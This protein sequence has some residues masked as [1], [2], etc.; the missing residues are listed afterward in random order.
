MKLLN[1]L[2]NWLEK[3]SGGS[4]A[5]NPLKEEP[6][7][8]FIYNDACSGSTDAPAADRVVFVDTNRG[9]H[10]VIVNHRGKICHFPGIEER[11]K[12][13]S[14]IDNG[15]L[16]PYARYHV[17]FDKRDDGYMMT[18]IVQPDGRYWADSDGFGAESDEEVCLYAMMDNNGRFTSPF[19]LY[20]IGVKNYFHGT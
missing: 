19:R 5:A 9:I 4:N 20:R 17:S 3:R 10:R 6:R 7:V 13:E 2:H 11:D 8:G 16:E 1:H 18:W 12:I 14:H 15:S